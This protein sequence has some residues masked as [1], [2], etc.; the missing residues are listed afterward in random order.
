MLKTRIYVIR[1]GLNRHSKLLTGAVNFSYRRISGGSDQFKSTFERIFS[2]P[3]GFKNFYP[4]DKSSGKK[5]SSSSSSSESSSSKRSNPTGGEDPKPSG[6][7][8]RP[9]PYAALAGAGAVLLVLATSI[10]LMGEDYGR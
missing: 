3:K 7:G 5:S 2:V 9:G 4:K 1:Q 10:E 6:G 8:P